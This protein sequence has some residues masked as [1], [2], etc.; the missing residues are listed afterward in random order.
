VAVGGMNIHYD[1]YIK[2]YCWLW[3]LNNA[4]IWD[5]G[6]PASIDNG[7]TSP[8]KEKFYESIIMLKDLASGKFLGWKLAW[9]KATSINLS[10]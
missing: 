10:F 8:F 4:S 1:W 2:N 3:N 5:T 9:V 6:S 7:G